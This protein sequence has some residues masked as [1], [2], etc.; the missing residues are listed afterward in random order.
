MRRLKADHN[1]KILCP[2]DI[3]T[4]VQ[5]VDQQWKDK[6]IHAYIPLAGVWKGTASLVHLMASGDN[7][8]IFT[9]LPVWLRSEQ[10]SFP[11]SAFLLPPPSP[12]TWSPTDYF[13]VSPKGSFSAYNYEALFKSLNWTQGY[14][15]Y[16]TVSKLLVDLPAPQV[17][18][19]CFYGTGLLTPVQFVYTDDY[20]DYFDHVKFGD[21]DGTVSVR[22]S[23]ACLQ[24]KSKQN[25]PFLHREFPSVVHITFERD[26]SV[27]EAI[28]EVVFMH[29]GT[30]TLIN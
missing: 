23:Q 17:P 24:W 3:Y 25:Q 14:D 7:Q 11:A 28:R 5:V 12:D 22:S 16:K 27:M 29:S 13:I 10:R 2:S 30:L 8:G 18:T 20:P 6:F 15:I 21:G 1:D 4:W 26:P 9:L 19:Y